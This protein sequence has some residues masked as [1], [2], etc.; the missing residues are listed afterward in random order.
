MSPTQTAEINDH[1]VNVYREHH[2]AT[3]SPMKH[4]IGT[5]ACMH[6]EFDFGEEHGHQPDDFDGWDGFQDALMDENDVE[7]IFPIYLYNHTNLA[8]QVGSF[9]GQLPQGHARFDSGQIGFLYV[10]EDEY[11]ELTDDQKENL[12]DIIDS[13]LENYTAYVNGHVYRYAIE[14][15]NGQ[16]VSGCGGFYSVDEALEAG[17]REARQ[18]TDDTKE[19][20]TD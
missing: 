18:V 11:E 7:E 20:V 6:G 2:E 1:T 10:T 19:T 9:H 12:R 4:G 5:L 13:Q 17:K 14:D 16:H 8:V 15:E 3:E